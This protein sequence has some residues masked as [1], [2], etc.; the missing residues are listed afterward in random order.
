MTP[1]HASHASRNGL[2]MI[3][4]SEWCGNGSRWNR[5]DARGLSVSYM[6]GLFTEF[7]V[8]SRIYRDLKHSELNLLVLFPCSA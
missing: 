2:C 5:L 8:I 6:L 4:D 3:R 1:N 7:T